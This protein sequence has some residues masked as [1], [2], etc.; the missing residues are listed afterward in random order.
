MKVIKR[1]DGLEIQGTKEECDY[2]RNEINHEIKRMT[3]LY[4]RF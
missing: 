1:K 4:P 3:Y 2:Y